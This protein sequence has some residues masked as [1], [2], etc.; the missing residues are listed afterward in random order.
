MKLTE[1]KGTKEEDLPII[2]DLLRAK[3]KAGA[4][5]N[6]ELRFRSKIRG[7]YP[8]YLNKLG[9]ISLDPDSMSNVCIDID[10]KTY[11]VDNKTIIDTIR[12]KWLSIAKLRSSTLEKTGPNEFLWKVKGL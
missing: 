1:I 5:I 12:Y 3:L 2:Y 4:T 9:D 11:A 10:Y 6:F 8:T 7:K